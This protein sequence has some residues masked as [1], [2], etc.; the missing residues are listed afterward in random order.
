M[1]WAHLLKHE[2]AKRRRASL[3]NI[4]DDTEL[5]RLALDSFQLIEL[6][7]GLEERHGIRIEMDDLRSVRTVGDLARLM[8][9]KQPG[10]A[11]SLCF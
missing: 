6:L 11:S 8:A 4:E 5:A 2:L 1:D 3:A 10:A 7:I 9:S